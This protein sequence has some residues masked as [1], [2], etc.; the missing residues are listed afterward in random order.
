MSA[1]LG[2]RVPPDMPGLTSRAGSAARQ[3][4]TPLRSFRPPSIVLAAAGTNQCP[5]SFRAQRDPRVGS[6]GRR[7][8]ESDAA[9]NPG[10]V[11]GFEFNG[12][13]GGHKARRLTAD[14]GGAAP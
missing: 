2:S 7:G 14:G 3:R 13:P 1:P 5:R 6:I 12:S 4:L 8:R 9:R 11:F 10:V